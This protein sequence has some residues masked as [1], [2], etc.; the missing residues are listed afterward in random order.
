MVLLS[1]QENELW[2]LWKKASDAVRA[3]VV[4]EIT[5]STGLSD[6]D[7][8]VLTR[9]V[10]L[11]GGQMRQ[12]KLAASMGYD[13]SR[14]SHHLTRMESRGLITRHPAPGV[15]VVVAVTEQGRDLVRTARRVH[16]DAVRRHLIEP[17][18]ASDR[19]TLISVL[20]ALSASEVS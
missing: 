13:R 11:G 7:F 18:D 14:L 20:K 2:T 4:A 19:A 1:A 12:N 5:S 8:G 17:V 15:G 10:E 6:P 16:A 3:R 9:V